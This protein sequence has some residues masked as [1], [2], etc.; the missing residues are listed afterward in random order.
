MEIGEQNIYFI[1]I[2]DR[3]IHFQSKN[4]QPQRVYGKMGHCLNGRN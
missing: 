3:E 4:Y 1:S 2:K